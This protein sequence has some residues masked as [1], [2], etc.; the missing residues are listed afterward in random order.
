MQI[1]S[2]L[3][4][5]FCLQSGIGLT[6]PHLGGDENAG[7]RLF[8]E[9]LQRHVREGK[10]DYAGMAKDEAFRKY[11]VWLRT[12]QPD[13]FDSKEEELAFWINAYNALAINAVINHY[14]LEKVINVD[15][16]F[17]ENQH[18]V[19]G[20]KFTLN[21][22]EKE[23]IFKKF[24][25]PK[26]HFVLVCAALSCPNLPSEAYTGKNVLR[27]MEEITARFL[28]DPEKN[29]LDEEQKVFYLS[30][31]FNW[32][33]KDFVSGAATVIDFVRPYL[34]GDKQAFLDK[35]K[36]RVEFLEYDWNLN[37]QE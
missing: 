7:H 37:I 30:Q 2:V 16:F 1:H 20:G 3:I 10:V 19:A 8:N 9:A 32:Y 6:K 5:I 29:R 18:S 31:I 34:D 26:L 27:K 17:D 15:G 35:N 4:A 11:L 14:P 33:Q 23:I 24:P 36:V 28:N 21:Q 25:E 12:V 22:I 13:S